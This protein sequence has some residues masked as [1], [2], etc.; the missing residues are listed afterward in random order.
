MVRIHIVNEL[1]ELNIL[2]ATERTGLVKNISLL[3]QGSKNN[4]PLF[5]NWNS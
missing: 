5:N 2:L 3:Q 4:L 1:C